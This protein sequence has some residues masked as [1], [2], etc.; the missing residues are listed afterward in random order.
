MR[1]FTLLVGACLLQAQPSVTLHPPV[2]T[3]CDSAVL[4]QTGVGQTGVGQTMVQWSDPGGGTV[5]VLVGTVQASL[6]GLVPASGST[7]TGLWVT[8]GMP[9]VL[10][11]AAGNQLAS[12]TA[13]VLCSPLGGP[14]A[15]GLAAASYLPLDIGN[16]WIYRTNNRTATSQYTQ[17]L[18]T[19]AQTVG[20][21][22]W[23]VI[24]LSASDV[25]SSDADTQMLMRQGDGGRI[26]ILQNE[27]AALWLDPNTPQDPSAQLQVTGR[28]PQ[29]NPLGAFADG[30]TYAKSQ[31]LIQETGT[32]VRG[33]GLTSSYANMLSGSSGGFTQS[34]VLVEAR[35]DGHLLFATQAPSLQ[36]SIE[37][38]T[39]DVTHGLVT[40]CI[41]P[42]YFAACKL[43]GIPPDP[44]GTYKPCF[45]AGARLAGVTTTVAVDLDILDA[46][47]NVLAHTAM[48]LIP[49][50]GG[51]TEG[52]Y[53][54]PLYTAPNQPFTPGNYRLSATAGGS[55][56]VL[57][58]Q[59]Q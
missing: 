37:A 39:F 57:A 59:V 35:I 42:C 47:G 6:T 46:S 58:F 24:Q 50:D 40:N 27:Q 22:L 36:L 20:G 41:L 34:M 54:M 25:Q 45:K 2:I 48:S 43:G 16:R 56:A 17:W 9:F 7:M 14:V 23:F 5:Q 3:D 11:D 1:C 33:L 10:V 21:Q 44:P 29:Q 31:D 26:Y 52:F 18:V 8:D 12:A 19:G 55:S 49:D 4:G 13:Q 53:Q 32:V 51:R 15:A 28:G 38:A 30:L